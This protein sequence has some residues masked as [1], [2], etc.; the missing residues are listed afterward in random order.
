MINAPGY[1]NEIKIA[2]YRYPG[3]EYAGATRPDML[4]QRKFC[5]HPRRS[6]GL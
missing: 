3:D 5:A 4:D 6:D 2:P 1:G